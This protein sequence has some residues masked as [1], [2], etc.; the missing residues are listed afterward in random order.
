M[1]FPS[2]R[3]S[4][5]TEWLTNLTQVVLIQS[6]QMLLDGNNFSREQWRADDQVHVAQFTCLHLWLYLQTLW[7]RDEIHG[8][9][10]DLRMHV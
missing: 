2:S 5:R 9:D 6:A 8:V 1:S 10:L 4:D 7:K 3:G